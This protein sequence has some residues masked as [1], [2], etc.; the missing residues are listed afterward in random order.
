MGDK[1]LL[2]QLP[3]NEDSCILL[4]VFFLQK[5]VKLQNKPLEGLLVSCPFDE[6]EWE[7]KKNFTLSYASIGWHVKLLKFTLF[8]HQ[9]IK[10]N[11]QQ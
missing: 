3:S 5:K 7:K 10:K 6:Q 2:L 8:S 11:S 1:L 9:K 4:M